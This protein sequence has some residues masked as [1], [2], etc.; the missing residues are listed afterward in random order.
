MKRYLQHIPYS[1]ISG[2]ESKFRIG[3]HI[4]FFDPMPSTGSPKI[5]FERNK[6]MIKLPVILQNGEIVTT[7]EI[8]LDTFTAKNIRDGN[9]SIEQLLTRLYHN[10]IIKTKTIKNLKDQPWGIEIITVTNISP[11]T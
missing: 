10:F 2:I 1:Q 5:E 8:G 6:K 9:Y 11:V 4:T 7:K 3:D